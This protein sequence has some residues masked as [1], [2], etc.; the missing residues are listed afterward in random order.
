MIQDTLAYIGKLTVGKLWAKLVAGVLAVVDWLLF[1]PTPRLVIFAGLLSLF[2][3]IT[4]RWRAKRD[5][6]FSSE[7]A[8]ERL[9]RKVA[10]WLLLASV[11][12]AAFS[13][14]ENLGLSG[15][16]FIALV[17]TFVMVVEELASIDENLDGTFLRPVI[18]F[19]ERIIDRAARGVVER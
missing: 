13:M 10:V 18:R 17:F 8:D 15:F 19:F 14:E 2:D 6:T 16:M 11:W 7:I 5:G 4:G 12:Y 9:F 3:W 1:D